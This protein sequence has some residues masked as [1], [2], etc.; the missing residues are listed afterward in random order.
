MTTANTMHPFDEA[1]QL[2]PQGDHYRGQTSAK[3]ANMVGPF[4]GVTAATLLRAV[5]DHPK[6][7]GEPLALTVN[8]A[9]PITD[10]A[11]DL[12]PKLIRTNRST[13]HWS[14]E[15]LQN[16]QI[17]ATATALFATRRE[18]W[19][20][21]EAQFPDLSDAGEGVAM[22]ATG[23]P[24]W[25]NRYHI[26]TLRG[27][28]GLNATAQETASDTVT[29]QWIRD[30]PPRAMD[31]C[32]LTAIADAFFPRI[33]IKRKQAVPAGTVSLTVYFHAD[34]ATLTAHGTQPVLG[35]AR[36]NRF[37]NNYFDQIAELWTP[38]GALLATTTQVVYYKE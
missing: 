20:A 4:G 25:V 35:Y 2:T 7:Q 22:P 15:L 9:A 6:C 33:F 19:S 13:Q 24:V 37:Y 27:H 3:Y 12:V 32:S 30:E 38:D 1:I 11:F 10:G 34:A 5:M 17:A 28:L 26:R 23:L 8:F 31:F 21:T 18:T 36:A 16:D 14:M 29:Q